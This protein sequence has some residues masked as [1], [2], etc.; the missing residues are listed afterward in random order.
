MYRNYEENRPRLRLVV[1]CFVSGIWLFFL[2]RNPVTIWKQIRVLKTSLIKIV[3]LVVTWNSEGLG[4][5]IYYFLWQRI[6]RSFETAA[7]PFTT[8]LVTGDVGNDGGCVGANR[9]WVIRKS[10][11][12]KM[13]SSYPWTL[14]HVFDVFLSILFYFVFWRRPC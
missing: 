14:P 6:I 2:A 10:I 4:M 12:T 9:I 11:S 13:L 8:Q 3:F 5:F 7:R 1:T